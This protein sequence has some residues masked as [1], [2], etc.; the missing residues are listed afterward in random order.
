MYS[1][2]VFNKLYFSIKEKY[3]IRIIYNVAKK[4]VNHFGNKV[5]NKIFSENGCTE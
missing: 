4:I 5:V 3:I 2:V 1:Y